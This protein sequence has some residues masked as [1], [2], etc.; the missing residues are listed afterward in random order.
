MQYLSQLQRSLYKAGLEIATV[1]ENKRYGRFACQ[2]S[3][4]FNRFTLIFIE[5][6]IEC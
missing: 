3:V 4:A 5:G 1:F 6:P 2:I